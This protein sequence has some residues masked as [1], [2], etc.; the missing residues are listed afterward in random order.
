[1]K[2]ENILI[3]DTSR[4]GIGLGLCKVQSAECKVQM[5]DSSKQSVELPTFVQNFLN[6][7]QVSFSDLSAIAVVVGPGSFT[8]I[9]LGI[10]YAR[11][12][13]IGLNIP[14]IPINVFEIYMARDPDAFVAID[15]GRGDCFVA[16]KLHEPCTME[17]D[18]LESEQMKCPKTVGHKP[19]DLRDAAAVV[20]EKFKSAVNEPVI[21][22]YLR[23]HYAETNLKAKDTDVSPA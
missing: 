16:S 12:L 20:L 3:I 13:S 8:G 7:N 1:M 15:T 17:I 21:P 2:P 18:E 6:D 23:P 11:G 19:Y 9:R 22:M 10:A 14:V 4:P 5:I